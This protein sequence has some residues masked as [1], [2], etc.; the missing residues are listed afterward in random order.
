[1]MKRLPTKEEWNAESVEERQRRLES[2]ARGFESLAQNLRKASAQLGRESQSRDQLR[3]FETHTVIREV[4]RKHVTKDQIEIVRRAMRRIH[5]PEHRQKQQEIL[6]R[7]LEE[8]HRDHPWALER[9]NRRRAMR[10]QP[11]TDIR[12]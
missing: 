10:A 12:H 5:S 7:S 2:A 9:L 6:R 3:G 1:M 4:R 11:P 8:F